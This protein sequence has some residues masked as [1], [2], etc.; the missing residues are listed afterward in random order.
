MFFS[1]VVYGGEW[2]TRHVGLSV[3]LHTFNEKTQVPVKYAVRE[4]PLSDAKLFDS[5]LL[6]MTGHES[7]TLN[8][9]EIAR[10]RRYLAQGGMLFAEACC[11]RKGFDASFRCSRSRPNT[12]SSR[13]RTRSVKWA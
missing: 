1:Q 13:C 12:P 8:D 9:D 5:P 11:G 2:K 4:V 10:L 3:L 6:Y 7:I